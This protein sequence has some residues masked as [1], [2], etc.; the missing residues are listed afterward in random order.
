MNIKKIA[1]MAGV[2][3]ATVSKIIN[4]YSDIGEET[5]RKVQKILDETGYKPSASA[6]T[7]A[8]KRSNI[9]GIIFAGKLNSDLTHPFFL[10]IINSFKKQ[11]G[12]LGYDILM[13][14]NEK[15]L[16]TKE[17]YLAR[18]RHFQVDGCVIIAGDQIEESVK[19][20]DQSNIPCIGIDIELTGS[21]SSYV[22]SDNIKISTKAVEHFYL[23]GYHEIG[24]LGIKRY[25]AIMSLRER[26]FKEALHNFG[27]PINPEWIIHGDGYEEENGYRAMMDLIDNGELPRAI[28]A[29]SDLLAFG[30][31]R[32][33][34]ER[35]YSVPED[36]AVIGCDD[37][38][39]CLYSDPR[40]STIKQDKE[41]IGRLAA[42]M[43]FDMINKQLEPRVVLTEPE[44]VVRDSCGSVSV[45]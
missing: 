3:V 41:K 6:K 44:M 9:I 40:L 17:D 37:I 13:F 29:A 18:C 42:M 19:D 23:C 11:I 21:N 33:L 30:A 25:S 14:S 35:K 39:A 16:S 31:M 15:F 45:V 1:E 8:T 20:L 36:I 32:A 43:L 26:A 24:F 5:R 4:N 27:L 22:M 7:L 2:S 10:S 12:T 34:K 28:F 38:D